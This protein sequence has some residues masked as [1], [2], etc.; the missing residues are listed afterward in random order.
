MRVPVLRWICL[1]PRMFKL[2]YF[3][4]VSESF[5]LQLVNRRGKR[6]KKRRVVF[7]SCAGIGIL[8][9]P[10]DLSAMLFS[11]LKERSGHFVFLRKAKLAR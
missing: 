3:G 9:S 11:E 1:L 4:G 2:D 6:N 5:A 7:S 10:A 8:D